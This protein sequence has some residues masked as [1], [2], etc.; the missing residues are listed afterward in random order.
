V[1]PTDELDVL[2]VGSGPAG[3]ATGIALSTIAPRLAEKTLCID[4]AAHPREKTCGGGLTGQMVR[5]IERLGVSLDIPKVKITACS[6]VYHS[7]RYDVGLEQPFYVIRRSALDALLA[8]AMT[9]RGVALSEGEA[10]VSHTRRDDGRVLVQTSKRE[11]LVKAI[12]AAD[13]A[14]S[15]LARDIGPRRRPSV[16]LAQTDVPLPDS[17]DPATMVYDFS[18]VT[19]ELFGYVWVFPTPLKTADG[20]PMANVGLMQVGSTRAGGGMSQML[21]DG[22]K[23]YGFD[24]VP[25]RLNFHPEW[26]FDPDYPF[27]APNILTVG[28]AAGIDPMF[29]EGLS[30]C[31][32]YGWLAAEELADAAAHGDYRFHRYRR[33]ILQSSM[34]R[35]LRAMSLPAKRFYRP[36]NRLWVSFVFNYPY[37][38][39]LM[40]AQGEGRVQL[41][42]RRGRIILRALGHLLFGDKTLPTPPIHG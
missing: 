2:I 23:R 19:S 9:T 37:L 22:L 40:A 20:Q 17:F 13:G 26:A 14:G 3:A 28:D 1:T 34:G 4:K 33:R 5:E 41:H 21:T 24:N 38:S 42:R 29:G 11:V 6:S 15:K 16:H 18:A 35:E 10:Y 31:L 25:E 32:E 36:K 8:N 7:R 12:V 39:R 30:Q 27:A